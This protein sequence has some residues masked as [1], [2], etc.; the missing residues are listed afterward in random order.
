MIFE[1]K[2]HDTSHFIL[3]SQDYA[4]AAQGLLWFHI[5]LMIICSNSVRNTNGISQ[6]NYN[7]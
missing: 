4:L 7:K 6:E 1:I 5:N 2:E 3:L